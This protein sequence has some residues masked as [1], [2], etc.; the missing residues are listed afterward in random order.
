VLKQL[1]FFLE[2][3][4]F[5]FPVQRKGWPVPAS[6]VFGMAIAYQEKPK[7]MIGR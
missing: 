1:A 2:K 7:G 6:M 5:T 3:I 4:L